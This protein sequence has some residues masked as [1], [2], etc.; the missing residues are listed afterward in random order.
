MSDPR[1]RTYHFVGSLIR[2]LAFPSETG[3]RCAILELTV[4]PGA[5]APPNHH[6]GEDESFYVLE[7]TFEFMLN[8]ETMQAGPGDFI[9]IPDG[10]LHAFSCSGDRPGKLL[11]VNAPGRAHEMFF[12]EAGDA[13]P[14]GTTEI[15]APDGPPDLEKIIAIAAKAGM[16]VV[17]PEGA[18]A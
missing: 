5:G 15:P 3:N 1:P 11:E 10:A 14:E 18:P 12:T 7:G 9:K 6:A 17:V 2:F 13:M 4:S 8:G 16:T